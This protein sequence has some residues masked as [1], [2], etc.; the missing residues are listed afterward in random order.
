[1]I[2]FCKHTPMCLYMLPHVLKMCFAKVTEDFYPLLKCPHVIVVNT[3]LSKSHL[4]RD[5]CHRF[6]SWEGKKTQSHLDL[7]KVSTKPA[8]GLCSMEANE[9]AVSWDKKAP[10]QGHAHRPFE[11]PDGVRC[12]GKTRS[13]WGPHLIKLDS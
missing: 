9:G 11:A 8:H 6:T 13:H 4:L 1:M 5:C 7:L 3:Y 12:F 2:S 10:K